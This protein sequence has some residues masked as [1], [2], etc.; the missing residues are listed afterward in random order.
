MRTVFLSIIGFFF[1]ILCNAQVAPDLYF[2][3]FTDKNNNTFSVSQPDQ[4][5]SPKAMQRRAEQQIQVNETDLPV[6]QMYI[7]SLQ[8]MGFE[9]RSTTKWLNGVVVYTTNTMML[10]ILSG[11]SFVESFV[12]CGD[13]VPSKKLDTEL[14]APLKGTKA[15]DYG[16]GYPQISQVN[17][18]YLHNLN[19]KGQ[20]ML[21]AVIDAGFEGA[22]TINCFDNLHAESR[23]VYT[24]DVVTRQPDV[25]GFHAHGTMVLSVMASD[26][27]GEMVGTAPEAEYALI[28]TEDGAT[29]NIVEEYY[30]ARGLEI[31]DSIGADVVNS[32]LGYSLFDITSNDH[33]WADLDG[34]TAPA[35]YAAEI[36][37]SKGMLIVVAAGNSGDDAWTKITVPA[38]AD[39]ILSAGSVDIN[40]IHSSFS[41]QGPSADGRVKP[42]VVSMGQDTYVYSTSGVLFQGS[43]TSFASPLLCGLST[44]LWQSLP[45]MNPQEILQYI[46]MSADQYN[47][48]DALRGY[49]LPDFADALFLA[50]NYTVPDIKEEFFYDVYPNPF[51]DAFYLKLYTTDSQMI[52]IS[53]YDI[54]GRVVLNTNT[55]VNGWEVNKIKVNTDNTLSSGVY[56]IQLTTESKRYTAIVTSQK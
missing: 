54:T 4:F 44:C 10:S 3:K 23:V 20:G 9:I 47:S 43:G 28:R 52:N 56:F 40:G 5:L 36:A 30:L 42:D 2:I 16:Y 21:I 35:S 41:S 33:T 22:D 17:G 46:R 48:P 45:Q 29:E 49:G 25:Y 11:I 13:M 24:W 6:T 26:I 32:S 14:K 50:V 53:V 38:D 55:Y 19:F 51:T 39:S 8:S 37:A 18:D 12:K 15:T 27:P 7:D 34:K 1:L 31:A